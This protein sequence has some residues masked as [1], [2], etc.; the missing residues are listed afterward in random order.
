MQ[1]KQPATL[2]WVWVVAWLVLAAPALPAQAPRVP[3][4][5]TAAINDANRMT[6][7]GNVHPYARPQ[8]DQGLSADSLPLEHM[9]L[10]LQRSARQE[11]AL[12]TLLAQQQDPSSPQFHKWLTPAQFG[13]Q[14]GPA[15]ADI[16]ATTD[17]LAS[18]G[19]R[20][21]SVSAG[22]TVIDFSGTA[23]QVRTAFRTE[24]HRYVVNGQ[25][26]WANA[27]DPQIPAALAP[28]IAG[29]NSLHNF[30]L[31]PLHHLLGS[32]SKSKTTGEVKPVNPLFSFPG[33]GGPCN[34]VGPADFATIYNVLPLWNAGVDGTGQAIAIAQNTN[35]NVQ[36]VRNFRSLFGLPPNDPHIIVN[37]IDPGITDPDSESEADLDVQWSGAVAKNAAI[38][39]V[40]SASGATDGVILSAQYVVDNNFAPIMSVSFGQCELF[41]GT[42]ANQQINQLWQQAAAEG[43]TVLVASG[44]EGSAACE[45]PVSQFS[46]TGLAVNGLASTPY[47]VAVGGTSFN[48]LGNSG[49]FWNSTNAPNTQASALGYIPET[50]WNDTCTN[51][52]LAS[53]GFSANGETNCNNAQLQQLGFLTVTGAGGGASKCTAPT[54][55]TPSTCAG[56]Y[57]KPS[58]QI[59][60][61]VPNDGFRDLPDVSLFSDGPFGTSFY[62]I[63]QSDQNPGGQACNLN[64]P[65]FDFL[66]VGGTSASAPAFA[67]I[68]AM[69]NQRTGTRQG[70]TNPTLYQ[71]ASSSRA[72]CASVAAP[73]GSCI[74]YDVTSGT[75]A[76]PCLKGSPNCTVSVSSDLY[77]V[78]SGYSTTGGYDLATGLGSVNATNLVN[79]W[80]VSGSGNPLS[81]FQILSSS[82]TITVPAPGKTASTAVTVNS[83]GGFSGTV[84]LSCAVA[85]TTVPNPP[86]CAFNPAFA[87][88][89]SAT[90]S[91]TVTLQV[92]STAPQSTLAVPAG[93]GGGAGVAVRSYFWAHTASRNPGWSMGPAGTIFFPAAGLVCFASVIFV[94]WEKRP[95][96][97]LLALGAFILLGAAAGCGNGS[98]APTGQIPGTP[99]GSYVVTITGSSE[100]LQ[101]TTNVFVSV[102]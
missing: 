88:L 3:A 76:M 24:I 25:E 64:S 101:Q 54:G 95:R 34:A 39:L 37:G 29:I 70:N 31:R 89:N 49:Q 40:V 41:L 2:K 84:L 26:H 96:A 22:R 53:L 78:L 72:S 18:Q 17:W 28:T 77:G 8:F 44:D 27:S 74:F 67:G 58:W 16:T 11:A 48:D 66:G 10:V 79:N 38:D 43:I 59:G 15:D 57:P 9:L 12:A 6:L 5:I 13:Q 47:D 50:S 92:S 75:N 93:A 32:F 52:Q 42:A 94:G 73:A 63:C 80:P 1:T 85:P 35:L 36:D 69:I 86:T 7:R 60:A 14:F 20:V 30:S 102:P 98:S 68:V 71:L 100:N 81:G 99:A 45:S 51:A 46:I 97:I 91:V 61:G 55:S 4:R 56:G 23:A 62:I 65:F 87:I 21:N 33:C 90:P 19:F 82:L 83:I